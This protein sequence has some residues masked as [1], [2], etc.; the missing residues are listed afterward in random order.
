MD[1][2]DVNKIM[3][4]AE[5]EK[6]RSRS[7]KENTRVTNDNV[8]V[9]DEEM[10][11]LQR[12]RNELTVP[13]RGVKRRTTL[14]SSDTP[15]SALDKCLR[16]RSPTHQKEMEIAAARLKPNII[17]DDDVFKRPLPFNSW[18]SK[19]NHK[20]PSRTFV[21]NESQQA[22][23]SSREYLSA[24]QSLS[25]RGQDE[26]LS[27][28]N[29]TLQRPVRA[30]TTSP[31][32]S[33]RSM[34]A[35]WSPECGLKRS[36]SQLSNESEFSDDFL[37]I[38]INNIDNRKISFPS[39]KIDKSITKSISIQNGSSKKLPLRVKVIGAGFSVTPQEEFR[40]IPMEART[41]NVK[42]TPS[43]IGP[44]RGC[45]IF[46]LT[47]NKQCSQTIP[48]YGY[49]GH[50]S[51]S[52]E[53]V[54]KG[55]Y[56]PAFITMGTV[57]DLTGP[58]EQEIKLFNKGTLPS[59]VTLAFER[60]KLSDF[61]LSNSITMEPTKLRIE[62]GKSA[63][64]KIRFKAT[65]MEIKKIISIN[66][67]VATIGE[68]CVISGDEPTR[69]RV[70]KNQHFVEPK[71]LEYLPKSLPNEVEIQTKVQNFKEDL[72]REKLTEFIQQF[73]TQEIALTIN[74]NLE[75]T[76]VQAEISLADDTRMSYKTFNNQ[77]NIPSAMDTLYS[78]DDEDDSLE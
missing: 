36:V 13:N 53:N 6:R 41:F 63:D 22:E 33:V 55:P 59:F 60:T 77:T 75:D 69:I 46:E 30:T 45:L 1:E 68:I 73:K 23:N 58:I 52:I 4:Q 78:M 10:D 44:A 20:S 24:M 27:L 48:L 25:L 71:F 54:Q 66:K 64:V 29:Y 32:S 7:E 2:L 74:R 40:M 9:Q 26:K 70:L 16:S 14:T 76:I 39:V 49:G 34:N 62:P 18:D 50:S 43:V 31:T 35:R 61:A 51:I 5:K 28:P 57:K 11:D 72:S 8:P 37:P 67:D 15:K 38:K 21:H 3:E 42:F 47:T 65:R 56:G 12:Y 19:S 17:N